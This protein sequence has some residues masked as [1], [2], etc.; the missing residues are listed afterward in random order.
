MTEEYKQELAR[1]LRACATEL[2]DIAAQFVA[3]AQELDPSSGPGIP[4]RSSHRS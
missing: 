2:R 4:D 1:Y 3:R